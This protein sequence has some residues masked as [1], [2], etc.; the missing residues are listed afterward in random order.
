[1]SN[2]T[3][4]GESPTYVTTFG[5]HNRYGFKVIGRVAYAFHAKVNRQEDDWTK[6]DEAM[7]AVGFIPKDGFMVIA[8]NVKSGREYEGKA[9]QLPVTVGR[10]Q[11]EKQLHE[12]LEKYE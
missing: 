5:P 2:R 4:M 10:A 3:S 9:Y 8:V 12:V 6:M 1:M 11:C 7:K